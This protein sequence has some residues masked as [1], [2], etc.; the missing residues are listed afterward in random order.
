MKV[1]NP[2]MAI[3]FFTYWLAFNIWFINILPYPLNTAIIVWCLCIGVFITYVIFLQR[4][5]IP[6]EQANRL[7]CSLDKM[8]SLFLVTTLNLL[9]VMFIVLDVEK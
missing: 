1:R 8:S 2:I 4:R 5:R 7:M 9:Y 6:E 3:I